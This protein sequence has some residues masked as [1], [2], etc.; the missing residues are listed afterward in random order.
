MKK[1]NAG[2][3]RKKVFVYDENGNRYMDF[4]S[5]AEFARYFGFSK[6]YIAVQEKKYFGE[7]II[8]VGDL[9]LYATNTAIGR[10]R[11]IKYVK[12]FNSK[13]VKRNISKDRKISC[14]NLNNELIST[15]KGIYYLKAFLGYIPSIYKEQP[16]H[17]KGEVY[18][19]YEE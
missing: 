13:F 10:D 6:N 4:K 2:R 19:L 3:Q 14:Y 12:K 7:D 5:E 1:M 15:F 18:Y 17:I 8:K 16:K 11:I 9:N